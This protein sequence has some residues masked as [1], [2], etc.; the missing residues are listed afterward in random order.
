MRMTLVQPRYPHGGAG[1]R[2]TY[3]AANLMNL[4]SRLMHVGIEVDFI[5]LNRTSWKQAKSSFIQSSFIGFT[6]LGPPYIPRIIEMIRVLRAL[7][8]NQ[9]ILVGGEGVAR[10]RRPHFNQWFEG[11]D[12]IQITCD[13]DLEVACGIKQDS[14]PNAYQTSMVPML[15]QLSTAEAEAYFSTEFPLFLSQGCKFSCEFCSASKGRTEQYRTEETL[16]EEIE[17]I[18][19][20]L[21]RF[22]RKHLQAYLTNLDGFQTPDKLEKCLQVI[23]KICSTHSI[24]PHLRCLAT[25]RCTFL[26]CQKDPNLPKRLRELGLEIVAFGVD[27]G[28]EETWKRQRKLHNSLSEIQTVCQ[29]MT[30]AG[31]AVELLMVIGFDSDGPRALWRDLKYSLQQAWKGRII[32]PYLAK[33]QT[34]SGRWPENNQQVRAFLRDASLLTRLDYAMIGSRHTHPRFLQRMM[35]NAVYLTVIGALAPFGRCPTRPLVPGEK[36]F[37]GMMA[38]AINTLMPFDR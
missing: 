15:R 28:D 2:Q 5:D 4:G 30:E 19:Q 27:G 32:R 24:T 33:S 26:A 11:L 12:V 22:G 20:F 37:A 6:A 1:K 23:K 38:G 18:C 31:I 21:H 34:P 35:V 10:V 8:F 16:A 7:G 36:G 29:Y 14:L 17:V 3:L 13:Y 25:S 9:K